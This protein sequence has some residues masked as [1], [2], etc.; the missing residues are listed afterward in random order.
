MTS[1]VEEA[2]QLVIEARVRA[3]YHEFAE[4]RYSRTDQR[5]RVTVAVVALIATMIAFFGIPKVAA[6]VMLVASIIAI[7]AGASRWRELATEHA[8]ARADAMR[9]RRLAEVAEVQARYSSDVD[10][11]SIEEAYLA[12][13]LLCRTF[14]ENPRL[15]RRARAEV[16]QE[17]GIASSASPPRTVEA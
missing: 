6:V 11:D 12:R 2:Q 13:S 14:E 4:S 1:L 3:K 7:V 9:M 15:M 10:R 16:E 17:M 5:V 8:K